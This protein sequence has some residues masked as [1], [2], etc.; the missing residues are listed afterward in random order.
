MHIRISCVLKISAIDYK[1][2]IVKDWFYAEKI[3]ECNVWE[4]RAWSMFSSF[5]WKLKM[6]FKL[7]SLFIQ[8]L[9]S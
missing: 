9:T 6:T 3:K 8:V 5:I 2:Y 4:F 7:N 1:M